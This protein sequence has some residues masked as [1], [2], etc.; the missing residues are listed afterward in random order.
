V[1]AWALVTGNRNKW[2][3]AERICGRSLERIEVDLP[4]IQA[5]TIREVAIE[6][7]RAAFAAVSRPL[8]VEDAGL[9]LAALGGFPGPFTKYWEEQGGLASICRALDGTP[10]RRATAVCALAIATEAGVEVVEGRCEG[11][12]AADPRGANGFGWDA[13][14]VPHGDVRTFAEMTGA[15]KD[16][17]SHRRAAWDAFRARFA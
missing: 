7:A 8:I 1:T 13:I 6:K 10:D 4:E 14:F 3:E 2:V 17:R 9:E 16:A 12:I 5:A 11:T 15:E